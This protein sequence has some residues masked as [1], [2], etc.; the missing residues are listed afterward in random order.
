VGNQKDYQTITMRILI[1]T[2]YY[3]PE[4]GAPQNRLS[5]LAKR[6]A[7]FGHIVTVLTALP[8]YPKGEIFEGYRGHTVIEEEI[9]GIR[10]I[11]TWIYVPKNKGFAQRLLNY[12]SFVFSSLTLGIWRVGRL[13]TV[14]VESPPLF[15]GLS[16]VFLSRLKRAQLVFNVSDLWPESAVAMGVLQNRTLIKLS[17]YLE[18]FLYRKAHLITGQT[19]GIVDNI[20]SRFP[21]KQVHLV[22]NGVDV[23]A[24]KLVSQISQREKIKKEFGNE[25]RFVIGYAGLHGLAQGLETV[26]Q[27]AQM[28]SGYPDLLFAFFG[29]GP[30]KERLIRLANQVG[31][32][33]VRFYPIQRT[34]RMPEVIASFDIA[35]IPLRKLDLFRGALPSK[36]FEAM[37]AA[38]PLVVSIEGEARILVEKAQ[39][40]ICVEP[41]NPRAMADAILQLYRD[42][43]RRRT[44]GQNGQR[45]VI[46][47]YDRCQIA[48]N[49]EYLIISGRRSD[50][51][52]AAATPEP[53]H[54]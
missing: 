49:F 23:E 17:K 39:A 2:Q 13:D 52:C 22:T 21:N 3:P 24:F 4:T 27:A 38:V 32:T 5:D 18:E 34:A 14:I 45:Y 53:P 47:H 41:E 50:T 19:Q 12:F 37:A 29:D 1:L 44:L 9:E 30:E 35:L 54:A 48:R 26:I 25:E 40:G 11:R 15:L 36:M 8:N 20:Q 46:K 28:L 51:S 33:N 7:K 6:L 42:P 10:V 43:V 31:S 16:G